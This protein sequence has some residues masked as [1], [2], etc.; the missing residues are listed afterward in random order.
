VKVIR[1]YR[2]NQHGGAVLVTLDDAPLG[3]PPLLP[4]ELRHSPAGF[5]FGY[6][7]SGPAELARAILIA[8]VPD[9]PVVRH[10]GCYQRFKAEVIARLQGDGFTLPSTAVENWYRAWRDSAVGQAIVQTVAD[11]RALQAEIDRLDAL[12]EEELR[13]QPP[14]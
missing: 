13:R 12:A 9:D 2:Q 1:G 8:L 6:L 10:P 11:E 14:D 4:N 7:G 5:N 3:L